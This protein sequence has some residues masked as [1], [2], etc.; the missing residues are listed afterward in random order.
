MFCLFISHGS[1]KE[2]VQRRIEK[3][4]NLLK[5]F[6]NYRKQALYECKFQQGFPD[7]AEQFTISSVAEMGLPST[8]KRV[9]FFLRSV[10]TCMALF[11]IRLTSFM[12]PLPKYHLSIRRY[13]A[14]KP[15]FTALRS[16][17]M[18]TVGF[19]LRS[20]STLLLMQSS[21]SR[22]LVYLFLSCF[23]LSPKLFLLPDSAYR[24]KSS[25][26]V[27]FVADVTFLKRGVVQY[28]EPLLFRIY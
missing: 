5:E 1:V 26:N 9:S 6:C 20:S 23:L 22:C 12:R 2:V 4:C 7:V 13:L 3:A 11:F 10:M 24:E 16:I 18:A 17:S 28:E 14:M 25:G 8:V 27:L 15:F 19:C 21:L